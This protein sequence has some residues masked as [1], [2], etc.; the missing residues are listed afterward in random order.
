MN[1][2]L[3]LEVRTST[4]V[5]FRVPARYTCVRAFEAPFDGVV[6]LE[7]GHA[8]MVG[9]DSA[10]VLMCVENTTELAEMHERLIGKGWQSKE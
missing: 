6:T 10:T 4:N 9:P 2:T 5:F 1:I 3:N 7:E 8:Y